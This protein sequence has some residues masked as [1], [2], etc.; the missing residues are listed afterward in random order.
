MVLLAFLGKL[1]RIRLRVRRNV[2]AARALLIAAIRQEPHSPVNT[3]IVADRT[4][5]RSHH[6]QTATAVRRNGR[7]ELPRHCQAMKKHIALAVRFRL[8]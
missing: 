8:E 2:E 6:A 3:E 1:R 7:Q 5:V 4:G